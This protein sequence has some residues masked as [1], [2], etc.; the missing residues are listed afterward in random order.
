MSTL[1]LLLTFSAMLGQTV[2][3]TPLPLNGAAN[4]NT[5]TYII[6][7]P[8]YSIKTLLFGSGVST[9]VQPDGATLMIQS[10]FAPPTSSG[11]LT[12]S[13]AVA[14]PAC[15]TCGQPT[16]GTEV[17]C[18]G[19]GPFGPNSTTGANLTPTF[20]FEER[21]V[22]AGGV[23]DLVIGLIQPGP[24]PGFPPTAPPTTVSFSPYWSRADNRCSTNPSLTFAS[25][26]LATGETRTSVQ[27]VV[28]Y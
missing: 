8:N 10:I 11:M 24:Q 16:D 20:G 26:Q 14:T 25:G 18:V 2:P 15:P 1:N 9:I 17:W 13:K 3:S 28:A 21:Q 6:I 22:A 19:S 4:P 12:L 23:Y 5:K 27:V 7:G